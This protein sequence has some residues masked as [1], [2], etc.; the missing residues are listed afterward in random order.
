MFNYVHINAIFICYRLRGGIDTKYMD[1]DED[2]LVD[3]SSVEEPNLLMTR[4][5]E[6]AASY[7]FVFITLLSVCSLT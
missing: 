3:L 1:R 7:L 4:K 6:E 5:S 2:G